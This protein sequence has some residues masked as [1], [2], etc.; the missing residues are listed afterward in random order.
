MGWSKLLLLSL[1]ER[2][3]AMALKSERILKVVSFQI[4][5]Q[6]KKQHQANPTKTFVNE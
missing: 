1:L 4:Q 2:Q 6:P 5:I 3:A